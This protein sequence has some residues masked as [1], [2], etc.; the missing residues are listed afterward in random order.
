MLI[1]AHV[2]SVTLN[3]KCKPELHAK[4]IA[5]SPACLVTILYY[6]IPDLCVL[7]VLHKESV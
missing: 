7:V 5:S 1:L 6:I 4:V 2:T 3:I